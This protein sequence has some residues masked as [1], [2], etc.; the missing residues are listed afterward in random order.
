DVDP[1]LRALARRVPPERL[2]YLSPLELTLR[3]EEASVLLAEAE[4]EGPGRKADSKRRQAKRVLEALTPAGYSLALATYA[5]EIRPGRPGRPAVCG[6]RGCRPG[7]P[8]QGQ[9]RSRAE[10]RSCP[11]RH[12]SPASALRRKRPADPSPGRE[13]AFASDWYRVGSA[14]YRGA[15]RARRP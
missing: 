15:G 1:D 11:V 7:R 2:E 13:A 9:G 5:Q 8:G 4:T 14:A 3:C 12:G 10:G 6:P